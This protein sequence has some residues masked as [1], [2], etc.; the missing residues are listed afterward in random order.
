[1]RRVV[2]VVAAMLMSC[3]QTSTAHRSASPEL[4]SV[5]ASSIS[6]SPALQASPSPLPTV[7]VTFSC[8]LP[9][10]TDVLRGG[11][12]SFPGGAFAADP[13]GEFTHDQ[14]SG[15]FR[16]AQ[17]PQLTGSEPFLF[18]DRALRRWLPASRAAVYPDG[19]SYAYV[20]TGTPQSV[21]VVDVAS[22][23]E[24]TIAAA[25]PRNA[26]VF[27]YG[28]GGVYLASD[29]ETGV[30][31]VDIHAGTER[32]L[33]SEKIVVA[34]ASGKAWLSTSLAN[35]VNPDT[36]VALD[37]AG[38][39]KSIWF[40]RDHLLVNLL[41]LTG[42]DLP[43]VSVQTAT[44]EDV[45]LVTSPGVAQ[46]IYSG[47]RVF[48]FSPIRDAHGVWLGSGTAGTYLYSS[49]AGTRRVSSTSGA[50]AGICA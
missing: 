24:R 10:R 43:V 21:H 5:P 40:H 49:G 39:S 2:A 3:G 17:Q 15:T 4:S 42:D 32:L 27:D 31:L 29:L 50:P 6:P 35:S 44:G 45:W 1:M 16:S 41:G 30:W 46:K 22:G 36:V 18:Y 8:R 13:A 28:T 7:A 26:R 20:T 37:L 12:V 19:A 23:R 38:T 11:F 47:P 9:V 25:R 33:T 48:D 14:G 34:V